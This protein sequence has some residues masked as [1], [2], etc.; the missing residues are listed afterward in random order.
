MD[1]EKIKWE[2]NF[3]EEIFQWVLGYLFYFYSF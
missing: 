3:Q 1:S 2:W